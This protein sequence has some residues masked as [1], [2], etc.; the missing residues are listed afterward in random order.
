MDGTN[1]L[2]RYWIPK[3]LAMASES[4]IKKCAREAETMAGRAAS[5]VERVS[6][7]R[8]AEGWLNMLPPRKR[9]TES[10]SEDEH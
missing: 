10:H 5:E 1:G 4:E 7:L 2:C 3:V 9:S 6:W 8:V